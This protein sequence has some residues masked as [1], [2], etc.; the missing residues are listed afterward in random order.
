MR[1]LVYGDSFAACP[2]NDRPGWTKILADKMNIPHINKAVGGA[3]TE[4]AIINFMDDVK[5]SNIHSDDIIIFVKSMAERIHF[6]HHNDNPGLANWSSINEYDEYESKRNWWFKLNKKY[7][8][9]YLINRD[10][11]LNYINHEAY[12]HLLKNFARENPKNLIVYLEAKPNNYVSI[13]SSEVL[14]NF[15]HPKIY[16][17]TLQN[18][19]YN[20]NIGYR[21]FVKYTTHDV[22]ENHLCIPNLKK[23]ASL[24]EEMI[25]TKNVG[26]IVYEA[27]ESNIYG[28]IRNLSE[29]MYWID[30]G[31]LYRNDWYIDRLKKL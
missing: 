30:K 20:A 8:E 12:Y 22:R 27:F 23:L 10:L 7:I 15:L 26:N 28:P 31:Y 17:Y 2:S 24:V 13:K 16:L 19:E 1:M 6:N 29:Y 21:E 11:R 14:S 4:K 18:N 25:Q 3:S 5:D 9:W